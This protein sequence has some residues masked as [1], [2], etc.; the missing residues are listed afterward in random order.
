MSGWIAKGAVLALFVGTI[1][2]AAPAAAEPSYPCTPE[3]EGHLF[4][5]PYD[6][7]S[8]A[9]GF[10]QCRAS[11]WRRIGTCTPSGGCP[12]PPDPNGPIVET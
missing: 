9:G 11:A 4:L 10:Y 6:D 3:A 1:G 8:D 2:S 5:V 12:T 7:P